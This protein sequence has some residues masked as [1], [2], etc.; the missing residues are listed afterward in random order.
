MEPIKSI[1][2]IRGIVGKTL[3]IK[4]VKGFAAAFVCTCFPG[5]P[6]KL[7]MGRDTRSTGKSLLESAAGDIT[8]FG[9]QDVDI[10]GIIPT[11]TGQFLVQKNKYI[12]GII[13]TASHNPSEWNGMKFIDRDGC[14][15]NQDR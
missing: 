6:G 7:L 1:S 12:G 13:F 2:G 5:P 3:T 8:M 14:F 4:D 15:I 11:P 10:C 9:H